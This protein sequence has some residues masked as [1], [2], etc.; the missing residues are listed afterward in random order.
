[1]FKVGERVIVIT[2]LSD[3]FGL[4]GY[5]REIED[6]Y[7]YV[8]YDEESKKIIESSNKDHFRYLTG[9]AFSPKSLRSYISFLREQ[10]LKILGI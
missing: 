1:M 2:P 8:D 3:K 9:E 5:V 10:K 4:T 6:S 7:V